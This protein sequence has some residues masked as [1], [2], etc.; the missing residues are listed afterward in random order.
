V[1]N[2]AG[3]DFGKFPQEDGEST[4]KCWWE[5]GLFGEVELK[6]EIGENR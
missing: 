5:K 4:R 2:D 6:I 3:D 1:G